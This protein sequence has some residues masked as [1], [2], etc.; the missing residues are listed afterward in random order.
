M[1]NKKKVKI[2]LLKGYK[3]II[4]ERFDKKFY[5]STRKR[6]LLEYIAEGK[7]EYIVNGI[8]IP[9]QKGD[10]LIMTGAGYPVIKADNIRRIFI[11]YNKKEIIEKDFNFLADFC[12]GNRIYEKIADLEKSYYKI[13]CEFI[14]C[15]CLE[16]E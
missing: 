16:D 14:G 13:E 7:G 8:S 3:V 11:S 15:L 9:F 5:N 4:G 2:N 6:R 10:M 1:R 12:K